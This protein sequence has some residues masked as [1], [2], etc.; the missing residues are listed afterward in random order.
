MSID[1]DILLNR[2]MEILTHLV[3]EIG[4]RP[5]GSQA[6]NLALDWLEG[7]FRTA[8]MDTLRF[9]V[10]FQP[11]PDFLPYFT[12]PA[13]GFA[14]VALT[15]AD[16]GWV[17][18]LL[19]LL[20]LL[21]PEGTLWLQKKLLKYQ[22]GSSNLLV[23]PAG[24][25]PGDVDIL[26]CAHVD[27]ARAVPAGPRLW[28]KWRDSSMYAMM[29]VANILII[30]GLFQLTGIDIGGFILTLGQSLAWAM[31]VL[32]FIQDI[33]EMTTSRNRYSPGANDNGSGTAILAATALAFA[34]DP[35]P[36][37][38]AGFLF[39][40]AEECGLHGARQF[41]AY[42]VENQM[43]IPVINLDMVGA[44]S[45]LR[46]IT[47]CGTI[48]PTHTNPGLNE[49]IKRAD[50]QA[51]FYNAPRRWGDFVPFAKAGIPS[52]HIENTGTSL[53]WAT[54]HTPD[55]TLE[56]IEPEQMRHVGEVILQLAWILEK[57]KPNPV[58]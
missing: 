3:S 14:L 33:F 52:A 9:P 30:P 8:K 46:I 37:L 45:E 21:F 49:L 32:L 39:T 1:P 51:M 50:P 13:I 29:R 18:L 10:K 47:R 28:K 56:V 6:E 38:Q 5:A 15:L 31:A 20:I 54:Y 58:E 43:K 25:P 7:E 2:S 24:T 34:E 36:G 48:A 26:F 4:P 11:E 17:T 27:T 12:I 55:D 16:H 40:G 19:P 22:E 35:P 57:N 53:S 23:I 41:A 44:G 42:M